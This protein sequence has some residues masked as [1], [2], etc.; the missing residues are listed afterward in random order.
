MIN[1]KE[2][3]VNSSKEVDHNRE[4]PDEIICKLMTTKVRLM[5]L[6]TKR[7]REAETNTPEP[8][9]TEVTE[10]LRVDKTNQVATKCITVVEMNMNSA[11]TRTALLT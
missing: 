7:D 11:E 9:A 8:Q 10:V 5:T 4:P 6:I 3:A 1:S 2:V